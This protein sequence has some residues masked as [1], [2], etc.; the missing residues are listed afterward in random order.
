MG[1]IL[2][3]GTASYSFLSSFTSN[4]ELF[5]DDVLVIANGQSSGSIVLQGGVYAKLKMLYRREA[6]S[7][8]S[9]GLSNF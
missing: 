7:G 5:V 3:P 4:F 9:G 2:P 8:I 6:N 1:L